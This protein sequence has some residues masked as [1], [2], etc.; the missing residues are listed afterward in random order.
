MKFFTS[1]THFGHQNI[2]K[3]C[4]RPFDSVEHMNE[5][6]VKNWNETV[7]PEDEV[8]VLGDVAMGQIDK[9]L[10][11]VA[12]LNGTKYLIVG[13]H[14]RIFPAVKESMR[15]KFYSVYAELFAGIMHSAQMQI[16]GHTVRLNH[17]PYEGD[18][19]GEDRYVEYRPVDDGMPLVHGHVHDAWKVKGRQFNVGI[20]VWDYRPV[21]ESVIVDWLEGLS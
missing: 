19:H 7:M 6:L 10:P 3:F 13:N 5:M 1:D 2:I 9:S 18:S 12:R 20:D 4:N 8:W 15:N 14:D 21:A 16:A 11:L 17:F